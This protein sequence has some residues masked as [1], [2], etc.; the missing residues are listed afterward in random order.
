MFNFFDCLRRLSGSSRA[1]TLARRT[2]ANALAEKDAALDSLF[3]TGT[4]GIAVVDLQSVRFVRVSRRFCEMMRR[5]AAELLTLGPPDIIHPDELDRVRTQWMGAMYGAGAWEDEVRHVGPDGG[6][7]WVRIGVSVWQR[8]ESGT[9]LRCI[10]VLQ[11]VSENIHAM[12]RLRVSEEMLRLGQKTGRIGS[13]SR[14]LRTGLIECDPQSREIIGLPPG[15]APFPTDAWLATVLAE[16]RDE[17]VA[18][19]RAAIQRGDA[20]VS[21]EYR[22]RG[23]PDGELRNMQMRARYTFDEQ[24]NA[25]RSVGVAID[26]TEIKKVEKRLRASETLMRMGMEIGQIGAYRRDLAR[27]GVIECGP[28]TRALQGLPAGDEPVPIGAWMAALD[29]PD[30]ERVVAE[31]KAAVAMRL[32]ELQ[33]HYRFRRAPGEALRHMEVRTRYEYDGDGRPLASVG[34]VID[35]THRIEAE[36]QLAYAAHHD[37]LTGLPN[38]VLFC[39]RMNE[40]LA[41]GHRGES[42]AVLCLDLDRFKEV[43][44][45]LGHPVGDRLLVEVSQRL[46]QELREM[47]TLARLGGDEFSVIQSGLSQP[48]D[49]S[50][51]ARRLIQRISEPFVI[52]GQQIVVGLSIGIAIAPDDGGQQDE[53]LK[54]ADMALYRAKAE[55]RGVWRYFEP[56]M[57]TRM[58]LRRALE[59]D[60]RRALERDEFV[61]FYQPIVDIQSR[62]IKSFEALIRWRHPELGLLAP[63]GFIPMCEDIGLIRPLGAWV[64]RQACADAALWPSSVGV[65]VNLSPA[66]FQ[67]RDL[68]ETVS[69]ALRDAGLPAHRLELE[70]TETVMLQ[71]TEA[72]LAT[73]HGLKRL[74][75]RIA[76][77]DFGTGYSSLSYLQSFPFDKVKIDRSFTQGLDRSRESDA[78]VKAVTSLCE[79]LQMSTTAEG[80]ETEEQFQALARKGCREAQG[81]LFSPAREV[82]EIPLLLERLGFADAL[83]QAAE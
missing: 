18:G 83:A 9:P 78:I 56:E 70:I 82:A 80:V 2:A 31:A 64:L 7:I 37:A 76:M 75:V 34:V 38:R 47:D 29:P 50:A 77:D 68:V 19:I 67:G 59:V 53:L 32:P 79:G 51:L 11:D 72:T 28:E 58:Q 39:E 44:D 23:L 41:R 40:A 65:A 3:D 6:V 14:D 26:V 12:E 15:D 1:L 60:L 13:F 73:L 43:N 66:Q 22:T 69:A 74:G 62:K 46:R 36:K 52:D 55:G 24:G 54:A 33:S 48:E 35:V 27:D 4:A 20:E 21:I 8:D 81:F 63:D 61:M 57:N 17:V 16:D 45:T 71:D 25:I 49:V 30:A 42:F 10:A 5:D